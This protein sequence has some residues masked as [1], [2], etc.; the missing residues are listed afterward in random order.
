M[1][2]YSRG[3]FEMRL[4]S[5]WL[6]VKGILKRFF[7][8]CCATAETRYDCS[9]WGGYGELEITIFSQFVKHRNPTGKGD[10]EEENKNINTD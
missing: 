6:S 9:D 1:S 2:P 8:I 4:T 3:H 7:M 5:F 10:P